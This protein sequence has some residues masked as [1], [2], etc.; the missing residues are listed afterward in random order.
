M[1][2]DADARGDARRTSTASATRSPAAAARSTRRSA[3]FRPLLRD[4]H[5]GRAEPVGPGHE[6]QALLRR[7]SAPPR[8]S[9]RPVAEEQAELFVNLDTTFARAARG[10]APVHP[11]LDH[12]GR[13]RA[14]RGDPLVPDPA[15]VPGQQ[16]GP[17]PRAAPGRARA[18]RR[19]R[20]ILADALEIGTPTLRRSR[21]AQPPPRV[22]AAR[23]AARSP[24]TRGR[25]ARRRAA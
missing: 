6:P 2:D 15:P 3:S 25:D 14:R 5:P 16:R 13:A 12:R 17:V 8:G 22:A 10:R 23:A 9:S 20:P 4:I 11:G 21:R 24:R 7:R 1:F 19:R 18:A